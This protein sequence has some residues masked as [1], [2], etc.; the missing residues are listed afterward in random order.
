MAIKIQ[1]TCVG[2]T[3]LV[4]SEIVWVH[5]KNQYQEV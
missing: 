3:G 1:I 5:I 4:V 2:G